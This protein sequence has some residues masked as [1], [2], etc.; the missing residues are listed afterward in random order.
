[1]AIT[2]DYSASPGAVLNAAYMTGK[3]KYQQAQQAAMLPF[4]R[5]RQQFQRQ[6]YLYDLAWQHRQQLAA[7]QKQLAAQQM[8]PV[9]PQELRPTAIPS[10][11]SRSMP[12]TEQTTG[13]GGRATQSHSRMSKQANRSL[14]ES[15]R[16]G[17]V[18]R[19]P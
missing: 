8:V 3:N 19:V 4:V 6:A 13:Q 7:Q 5:D 15:C 11:T 17:N 12:S 18:K 9:G 2:I 1:M 16:K 14:R 10:T